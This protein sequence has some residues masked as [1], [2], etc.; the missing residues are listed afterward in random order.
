MWG[1]VVFV[2][3][4]QWSHELKWAGVN[5]MQPSQDVYAEKAASSRAREVSSAENVV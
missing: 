5:V 2:E 3:T 4:W 1:N